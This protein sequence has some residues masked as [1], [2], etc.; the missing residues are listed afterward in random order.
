MSSHPPSIRAR[1]LGA[2][3][4]RKREQA[5]YSGMDLARRTGWSHSKISRLESGDRGTTVADIAYLLGFF[6]CS[7]AETARLLDLLRD[8]PEGVWA[9]PR[10]RTPPAHEASAI[11]AYAPLLVPPLLR[12]E[13]YTEALGHPP[14][15]SSPLH[16]AYPPTAHF[17]LDEAALH[18]RVGT[19]ETMHDQLLHLV[20]ASNWPHVAIR[21]IPLSAGAHAGLSGEFS[22]LRYGQDRPVVHLPQETQDLYLESAPDIATYR[23]ILA[24]LD[25]IALSPTDTRTLLTTLAATTAT[26]ATAA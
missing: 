24:E 2:E 6:G 7:D 11:Q 17:H 25:H 20:F 5:G 3:L 18:R 21:V 16:R 13:A 15:A 19:P 8:A 1:A 9:C 26:T 22:L 10:P 4:R 14:A 23:N 12:T